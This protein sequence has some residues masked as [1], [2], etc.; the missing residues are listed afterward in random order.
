VSI[1]RAI[2]AL[3]FVVL[4]VAALLAGTT[5]TTAPSRP[6]G[7][8][9]LPATTKPSRSL[10]E[11]KLSATLLY[12]IARATEPPDRAAANRLET[13]VKVDDRQRALVDIRSAV[14][15]ELRDQIDTMG[16]AVVSSV[17]Q[18][19]S[20][21]AWIPLLML[22]RL[23]TRASVKSIVPAAELALH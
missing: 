3:I 7:R 12:E 9:Q 17:P 15:A 22:V 4:G 11:Q 16:G 20:T 8:L 5:E 23:A 19:E 14:T 2:P 1:L 6:V 10:A 21:V 13:G 18:Y